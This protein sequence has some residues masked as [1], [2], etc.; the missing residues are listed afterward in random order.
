MRIST[1]ILLYFLFVSNLYSQKTIKNGVVDF[2]VMVAK[3]DANAP[4][5]PD[6]LFVPTMLSYTHYFSSNTF[7]LENINRDS[8]IRIRHHRSKNGQ[9]SYFFNLEDQSYK[10][11]ELSETPFAGEKSTD[12]LDVKVISGY[13]CYKEKYFVSDN[14]YI[15]LYVTKSIK[16]GFNYYKQIFPSLKGFPLE[17]IIYRNQQVYKYSAKSVNA[18][19]DNYPLLPDLQQYELLKEGSLKEKLMALIRA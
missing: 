6:S 8:T 2:V 9:G 16:P 4:V 17:I 12:R 14:N 18:L 3:Q 11:D 10:I 5:V 1:I 13:N 15:E 19:P 7:L